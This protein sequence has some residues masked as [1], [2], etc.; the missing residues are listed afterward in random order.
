M[1]AARYTVLGV[2]FSVVIGQ[3]AIAGPIYTLKDLGTVSFADIGDQANERIY[4]T[5]T[6][7]IGYG[8]APSQGPYTIGVDNSTSD[9]FGPTGYVTPVGGS[10]ITI[11]PP[12]GWPS[13]FAYTTAMPEEVNA[14]GEVVGYA[15]GPSLS[16]A[17]IFQVGGDQNGTA[18]FL[19]Q[20]TQLYSPN[21]T[22]GTGNGLYV[23]VSAAF[24]INAVGQIVG[25]AGNE[26]LLHAFVYSNGI[27]TDLNSL[28]SPGS[29]LTLNSA[30]SINDLGEIV[31]YATDSSGNTHD[32]LLVPLS[33]PEPGTF[34]ILSVGILLLTVGRFFGCCDSR[35]A[36]QP[37]KRGRR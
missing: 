9:T 6:G 19:P 37:E 24:G 32:Y 20:L 18:A 15:Y 4:I 23:N 2:I 5:N 13:G 31:G 36:Y 8:T 30:V 35:G 1:N 33:T 16:H 26:A 3:G 27:S 21:G 17:V 11:A 29:G 14:S 10:R 25:E 12:S 22:N 7:Q 34:Q 28:I